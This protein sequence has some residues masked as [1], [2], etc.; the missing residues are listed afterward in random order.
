MNNKPIVSIIIPCYN[1]GHFIGE[2]IESVEQCDSQSYE[3][4]IVD[5]GSTDENTRA[6]LKN[7]REKG[8]NVIEQENKG[9]AAARNTG[10]AAAAGKYILPLDSDDKINPSYLSL[11]VEVLEKNQE[12][13]VVYGRAEFFGSK[14]GEWKLPDFE[15]EKLL[16]YNYIYV[17]AVYRKKVW[18]QCGGYDTD[19]KI[20]GWED[21]DFWLSASAKGWKFTQL[22]ETVFRYRIHEASKMEPHRAKQQVPPAIQQ[23]IMCKHSELY[24][25]HFVALYG[26]AVLSNHW[27]SHPLRGIA[28]LSLM[29][30]KA[31]LNYTR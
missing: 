9:V 4:I 26:D 25:K 30:L 27:K 12:V 1:Y 6:V 11:A 10:V 13:G 8:Y 24:R 19:P 28:R 23:Y 20:D 15:L 29:Q 18:T 17:S 21:W 22:E 31:F 5:D 3:L 7:L 14:R 16:I 2:T